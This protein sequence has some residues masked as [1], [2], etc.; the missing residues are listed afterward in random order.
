[1]RTSKLMWLVA[2]CVA[3]LLV[4]T[5]SGQALAAGVRAKVEARLRSLQ[6]W[7]TDPT[8]VNAVRVHNANPPAAD[9]AMTNDRW[10]MLTVVDPFVRGFSKNPLAL[11][12]KS[13]KDAPIAECFVSGIDGTK[14][15]FLSKPTN[16]SHAGMDK[17]QVPM[18]GRTYLG[19]LAEDESTR[20]ELVQIGIPVL[21][22]GRPIGSIVVGLKVSKL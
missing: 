16:W 21:D 2:G 20:Q 5:S 22:G 10:A 14:V 17:H 13:K 6:Q 12:L 11:Y 8:I 15:A 7:S 9:K 19:P 3:L 1:M 4:Q 18:T